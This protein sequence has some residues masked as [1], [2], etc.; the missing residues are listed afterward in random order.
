MK[1]NN[2]IDNYYFERFYYKKHRRLHGIGY[3]E[4]IQRALDSE[5]K[6]EKYEDLI[7]KFGE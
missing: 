5:N 1:I 7:K 3:D 6:I 4:E 2:L